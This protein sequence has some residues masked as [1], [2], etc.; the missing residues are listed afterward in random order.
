MRNIGRAPSVIAIAIAAA[1]CGQPDR[2]APRPRDRPGHA[3]GDPAARADDL[4]RKIDDVLGDA[5]AKAQP[6]TPGQP[7]APVPLVRSKLDPTC[8]GAGTVTQLRARGDKLIA[9]LAAPGST[10]ADA[11]AT[12]SRATGKFLEVVPVFEVEDDGSALLAVETPPDPEA[13]DPRVTLDGDAIQACPEDRICER[14]MP[15]VKD[16]ESIDVVRG[17]A[18]HR[19]VAVEISDLS[20][21]N[22]RVEIWDLASGR[23][24]AR[25]PLK[26]P[27]DLGF[28]YAVRAY[29]DAFVVLAKRDDNGRASA[30]L[31]GLDGAR[32]PLANGASALVPEQIVEPA[33][34]QLA[35]LEQGEA[36]PVVVYVHASPSGALIGRFAIPATHDDDAALVKGDRGTLG[37]VQTRGDQLRIDVIDVRGGGARAYVAPAC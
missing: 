9:C 21:K 2:A 20:S 37:V 4:K 24:R 7:P 15:L 10:T 26:L 3:D 18:R 29:G 30:T 32:H 31:F 8:V 11:C 12:W 13:D 28:S 23:L 36:G 25:H 33:P 5:I 27:A 6:V 1:A 17:D 16:G 35:V 22:A 19:A 14:F 34:G